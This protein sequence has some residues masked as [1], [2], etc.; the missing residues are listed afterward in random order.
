[1]QSSGGGGGDGGTPM[2]V[3]CCNEVQDY[4]PVVL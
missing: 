2:V 3:R 4:F 1:M